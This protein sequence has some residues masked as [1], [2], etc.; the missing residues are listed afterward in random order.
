MEFAIYECDHVANESRA[1]PC[2]LREMDHVRWITGKAAFAS[3][4]HVNERSCEDKIYVRRS[5][6]AASG[7]FSRKCHR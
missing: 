5:C 6:C 7:G 1:N 3:R 4:V 2:V